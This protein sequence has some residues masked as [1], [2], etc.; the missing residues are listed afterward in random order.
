M[1]VP[2]RIGSPPSDPDQ[3]VNSDEDALYLECAGGGL[4]GTVVSGHYTPWRRGPTRG[5]GRRARRHQEVTWRINSR[6]LIV[7]NYD[8]RLRCRPRPRH[9]A[10]TVGRASRGAWARDAAEETEQRWEERLVADPDALDL[11]KVAT[12]LSLDLVVQM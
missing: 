8:F 1:L 12:P 2:P 4:M 6:H 3:I 5:G 10:R 7:D 9:L 11:D